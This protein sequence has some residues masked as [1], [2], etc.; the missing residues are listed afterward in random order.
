MLKQRFVLDTSALTDTNAREGVGD[1]TLDYYM[2]NT[3]DM[4]ADARLLLGISCYIP[5][6]SV[7]NEMMTFARNNNCDEST[8]AKIDTWLVK[9]APDRYEVKI[10]SKIFYE[11]VDHMRTRINKGMGI[12]EDII[13]EAA[14]VCLFTT[15]RATSRKE[16]E[17]EIEREVV[18]SLIGKFREKYRGA[19]R[20]GI[21]DS[22]PDIDVLLL[23]KE[24]DAA[25]VASDLG[26]QRWSEELG[27]R[28]VD[29]RG[30]PLMVKE[31]LSK[32]QD[33]GGRA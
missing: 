23:A 24:L 3:L 14:T 1:G 18:G 16:I 25:V 30:F 15:T 27:L 10:P 22:A 12:A 33:G 32:V 5:Y 31:Y 6:P 2:A 9:K 26:I 7:Y 21:L 19:M 17:A 28:F 11:Y 20:Y 4:I 8:L 13:W 29:A